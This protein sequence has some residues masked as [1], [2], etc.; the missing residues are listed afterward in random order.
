MLTMT[1]E[2]QRQ[3]NEMT[4]KSQRK[5]K[6][7]SYTVIGIDRTVLKPSSHD[8]LVQ[9]H[10]KAS[11]HSKEKD[12]DKLDR[13]LPGVLAEGIAYTVNSVIV[14]GYIDKK[15]SG[16][17]WIGSRAWKARWAVLVVRINSDMIHRKID[18]FLIRS[19]FLFLTLIFLTAYCTGTIVTYC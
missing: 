15:G 18:S 7:V 5:P 16:F 2:Y 11:D 3:D 17:D 6:D 8:N 12:L 10:S 1:K 19:L 9:I 13:M 14:Q 4:K